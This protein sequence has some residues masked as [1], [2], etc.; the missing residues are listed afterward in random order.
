MKPKELKNCNFY[1]KII[2]DHNL[3]PRDLW[4]FLNDKDF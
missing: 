4:R 1:E 2:K 3:R